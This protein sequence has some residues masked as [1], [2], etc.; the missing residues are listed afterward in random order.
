M[1]L[2]AMN[3]FTKHEVMI[4]Q[5]N[6]VEPLKI[7]LYPL[8]VIVVILDGKEANKVEITLSPFGNYKK[9]ENSNLEG[10]LHGQFP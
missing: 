3:Q 7:I 1:K 2:K 9:L 4:K 10:I 6:M 8:E 5:T